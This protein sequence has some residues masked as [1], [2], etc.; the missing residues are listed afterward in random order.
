[1]TQPR[2]ETP[3]LE[4]LIERA[5]AVG[6]GTGLWAS[7][8]Q[9]AAAE[10][11]LGV[12]FDRSYRQLMT[13]CNGIERLGEMT[14]FSVDELGTSQRWRDAHQFMY[15]EYF[16][17]YTP[18]F[19]MRGDTMV[20]PEFYPPPAGRRPVTLGYNEGSPTQVVC[21][22]S[23][24]DPDA[25][26]GEVAECRCEPNLTGPL[27]RTVASWVEEAEQFDREYGGAPFDSLHDT[28][29]T[30]QHAVTVDNVV[31]A[32][33]CLSARWRATYDQHAPIEM[34]D[35]LR[36]QLWPPRLPPD[37]H[38]AGTRPAHLPSDRHPRVHPARLG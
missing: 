36:T 16:L 7:P 30:L 4:E 29:M 10:Q 31:G 6:A 35:D 21:N 13:L 3:S 9:I 28:I 27:E 20:E 5:V 15:F 18:S 26:P 8:E 23:L 32:R 1:M 22:F 14:L 25:E 24:D 19:E 12:R 38:S 11:R 37:P 17:L 34:L 33:R 2:V